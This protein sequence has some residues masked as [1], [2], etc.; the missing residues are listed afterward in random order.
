MD[1]LGNV[2]VAVKN[3]AGSVGV[4]TKVFEN[5]PLTFFDT[6]EFVLSQSANLIKPVTSRSKNCSGNL[7]PVF[8]NTRKLVKARS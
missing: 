3:E 6:L 5:Q 1:F 2:G 4:R 8:I 7:L